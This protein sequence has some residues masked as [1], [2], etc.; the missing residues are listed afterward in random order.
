MNDWI[1][2]G[3]VV[4]VALCG[5]IGLVRLS[6]PYDVTPEEF[7]K[8]AHEAPSLIS[9]G[10]AGLQKLLDPAAGKGMEVQEDLKQ[11]YYN[12]EQESGDGPEAGFHGNG[13]AQPG[14]SDDDDN[15]E[16]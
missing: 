16:T 1:G 3:V 4:F 5:L 6:K 13:A 10:F 7:E 8:R 2:L 9:S 15:E 12:G 14:P 11:G